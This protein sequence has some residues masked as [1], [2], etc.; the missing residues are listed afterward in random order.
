[1]S[2]QHILRV[3]GKGQLSLAPDQVRLSLEIEG[4]QPEYLDAVKRATKETKR[5]QKVL[6]KL[7]FDRADLKTTYFNVSP[8]YERYE[9]WDDDHMEKKWENRLEGYQ[10]RQ[11]LKLEF[12]RDN[13]RMG[14]VLYALSHSSVHPEIRISYTIKDQEA[15]KN[16]LIA[17]AVCDAKSKAEILAEAAGVELQSVQSID[18]SWGRLEFEVKPYGNAD[19]GCVMGAPAAPSAP[20]A[21]F[22]Y[23]V[24]PDDIQVEDTVTVVWE[25]S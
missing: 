13:E 9:V 2:Q 6:E 21:S 18:Y 17:K 4:I 12:D 20:P 5:L 22:D 14:Q 25:I 15:A 19:I 7:D 3:T 10:Y 8:N 16:K 24:E 11:T 1:M 23:D